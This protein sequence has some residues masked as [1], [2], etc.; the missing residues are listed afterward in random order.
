MLTRPPRCSLPPP[1]RPPI[2][3]GLLE[4]V[5]LYGSVVCGLR[6]A[7]LCGPLERLQRRAPTLILQGRG[8]HVCCST[9][10]LEGLVSFSVTSLAAGR[11]TWA[12][13]EF[14]HL[15]RVIGSLCQ[16]QAPGRRRRT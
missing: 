12:W 11:R 4:P 6:Q 1:F 8:K 2:I 10:V 9:A 3:R 5:L 13:A 15:T 14:L 7:G 16:R